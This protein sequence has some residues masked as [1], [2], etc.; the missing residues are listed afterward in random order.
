MLEKCACFVKQQEMESSLS[1]ED[2]QELKQA[3]YVI[4]SL[5]ILFMIPTSV[6]IAAFLV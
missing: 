2:L 4:C 6:V 1:L 3:F 5:L